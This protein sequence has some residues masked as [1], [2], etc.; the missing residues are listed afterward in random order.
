MYSSFAYHY[1]RCVLKLLR[2][3]RNNEFSNNTNI[4]LVCK[5]HSTACLP[6]AFNVKHISN[7]MFVSGRKTEA[8]DDYMF[9]LL[10]VFF[11]LHVKEIP[12]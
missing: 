7:K 8:L 3:S 6:S 12:Q 2:S 9:N 10:T 4:A 1:N 5:S 11:M